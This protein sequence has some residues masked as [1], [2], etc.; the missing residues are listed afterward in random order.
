[1]NLPYSQNAGLYVHIPFCLRKCPYCD[2]YSVTDLSLKP[3]FLKALMAEMGLISAEGLCFDTLYI[4]GGTPSVYGHHD[5]GKIVSAGFE[6]FDLKP[7][8]EFTIEVNPGTV[9]IDQLK[10]YREAGINRINIG[11][12]SF[13]QDNLDFLGRIH[14]AGEAR[15][16]V[17]EAQRAGFQNMGL[18]LIYGL[19]DQSEGDW[20]EN[21]KSAVEYDP[22]HLSCYTLTY[23]KGTPFYNRL[24]DGRIQPLAEEKVRALFEA[25]IDFLENHGYFQYEISNFARIG[26]NGRPHVSRHNLKYW[27]LVPYIGLGAS[28]HSFSENQRYWN[29]SDVADYTAAIE[30]GRLPEAGREELSREQQ[31]IETI[32]L[33]LRTT[34]GIDLI[35][36]G[37]KFG[38]NFVKTFKEVLSVLAELNYLEIRNNRC[39]LTRR[40]RAFLDSI[41]L[42]F[43]VRDVS[44]AESKN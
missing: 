28:A 32:Y 26:K 15:S 2:F 12:Q 31:I 29:V 40:A 11:V 14:T 16:A 19:P 20:L 41:A 34:A 18:D 1:M 27:T 43:V 30:S 8:S 42:M 9:S 23:E 36:F 38:I 7:E 39:A 35:G 4:G 13:F 24:K 22:T 37:Q 25:T 33:G 44:E 6:N 10:G 5:I 21:L 3:R 17:T